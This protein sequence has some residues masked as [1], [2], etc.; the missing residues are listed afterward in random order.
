MARRFRSQSRLWHLGVLFAVRRGTGGHR[1][2]HRT[3]ER[4]A[5]RCRGF[6]AGTCIDRRTGAGEPN[7]SPRNAW[8]VLQRRPAAIRRS[9][10]PS[11]RS[12]TNRACDSAGRP[13]SNRS[14]RAAHRNDTIKTLRVDLPP[15]LTVNPEATAEQCP[16]DRIPPQPKSRGETS[17]RTVTPRHQVGRRQITLVTNKADVE[18]APGVRNHRSRK[19]S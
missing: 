6:Q 4:T 8:P 7:C 9:A 19:A 2:H 12:S 5:D 11:T 3:A 10:S 1:R 16:L 13:A 14:N 18:F 17:S 15:G